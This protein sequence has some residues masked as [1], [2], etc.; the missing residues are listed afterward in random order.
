MTDPAEMAKL[1]A[2]L[3]R[4]ATCLE[5]WAKG[6]GPHPDTVRGVSAVT[7]ERIRK[8]AAMLDQLASTKWTPDAESQRMRA[9]LDNTPV[10]STMSA[11]EVREK[12][13]RELYEC[14]CW[15]GT[16]PEPQGDV[17]ERYHKWDDLG[18]IAD[19]LIRA[20]SLTK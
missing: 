7:A 3:N 9:I 8:A 1:A 17:P 13:Q 11:E 18:E 12:I 16:L 19:R 14:L 15:W 20:M 5:A 10:A 4:D 6:I 2:R